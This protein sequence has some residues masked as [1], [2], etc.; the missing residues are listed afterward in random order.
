MR[1]GVQEFVSLG[2]GGVWEFRS[3]AVHE[4]RS[5]G[6]VEFKSTSSESLGVSQVEL[7]A[8]IMFEK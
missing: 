6:D 1:S 5:S 7:L 3:L 8:S 4:F 2:D